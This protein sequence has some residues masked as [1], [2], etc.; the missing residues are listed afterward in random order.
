MVVMMLLFA[1]VISIFLPVSNGRTV[2]NECLISSLPHI[3]WWDCI[4]DEPVDLL[5]HSSLSNIWFLMV[6]M[7]VLLGGQIKLIWVEGR[8]GGTVGDECL[9]APLP[10]V[11]W[12]N[13]V[14][15][16]AVHLLIHSSF[17]DVSFV[18]LMVMLL[19]GE[20]K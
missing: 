18:V 10:S 16:E 8:W 20:V 12:L 3:K 11:Q 14:V 2:W 15:D 6:F 17:S 19:G 4:M 5:V 1:E 13:A 7:M 9:S